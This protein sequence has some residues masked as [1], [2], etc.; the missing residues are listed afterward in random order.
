[1]NLENETLV[2]DIQKSFVGLLN[3]F[4]PKGVLQKAKLNQPIKIL[5]IGCGRFREAKS[6]FDFFKSKSINFKLY[7]VEIDK[8]LLDL[9]KEEQVIKEN[10]DI[11]FLKL[12][13]ASII[14]FYSD[15]LVDGQFDLIIIRHPEITFNTDVFIK[16]FS[17]CFSLLKDDG[18]LFV[19]THF[20]SEKEA[21][22]FLLKL[23]KLN[24][25]LETENLNSP[26]IKVKGEV[27]YADK[28]LLI[29]NNT[30]LR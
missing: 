28:F 1:M 23:T 29:A 3:D 14:E 27:R 25:L 26:L 10:K 18:Y 21:M 17:N 22:K 30:E 19:T 15:W 2:I 9:A 13:D 11:V 24:L 5:S 12:A 20:E 7:G 6:I 4:L 16:I 8:E